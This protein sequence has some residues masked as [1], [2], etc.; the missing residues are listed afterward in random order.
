MENLLQHKDFEQLTQ[1][2]KAQ[3]LA[4]MSEMDYRAQRKVLLATQ[5]LRAKTEQ[6]KPN[7]LLLHQLRGKF[8]P[9]AKRVPIWQCS[10]PVWAVAASLL[11]VV[12]MAALWKS[13]PKIEQIYVENTKVIYDTL[14]QKIPYTKVIFKIKYE[15]VI[16]D[17]T[18]KINDLDE[19]IFQQKE[20]ILNFDFAEEDIETSISE[21]KSVAEDTLT[22]AILMRLK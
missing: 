7:P 8:E 19:N 20:K 21:G 14:M 12:A 9:E 11:A 13:E 10:V 4:E 3:V 15:Q 5:S 2:E 22:W 6:L 1:I 16:V 18:Q 17:N